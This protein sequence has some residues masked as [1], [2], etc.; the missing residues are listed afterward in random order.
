MALGTML[1][2]AGCGG[3]GTKSAGSSTISSQ[4]FVASANAICSQ[5]N[6]RV[7]AVYESPKPPDLANFEH[8]IND[9][10]PSAELSAQ[11]RL[12]P[13]Q[14]I[15]LTGRDTWRRSSRFSR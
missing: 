9:T 8:R 2:A 15:R 10:I 7:A 13:Q 14:A 4:A 1:L 11:Q 6:A 12:T 3:S 5:A